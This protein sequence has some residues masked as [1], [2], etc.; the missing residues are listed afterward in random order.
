MCRVAAQSRSSRRF[1]ST[2]AIPG[3]SGLHGEAPGLATP[4]H[5]WCARPRDSVA[6]GGEAV[7]RVGAY[8]FGAEDLIVGMGI[9]GPV[10]RP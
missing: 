3:L 2:R 4:N 5:P 9:S 8:A 10:A 1:N 7:S 6:C